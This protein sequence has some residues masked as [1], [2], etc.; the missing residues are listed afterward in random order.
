MMYASHVNTYE[1]SDFPKLYI[2]YQL[3]M[4]NIFLRVEV[5]QSLYF[6]TFLIYLFFTVLIVD[7]YRIRVRVE[8]EFKVEYAFLAP[9]SPRPS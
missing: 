3:I 5:A 4:R 8:F 7:E 9:R 2:S 1:L 6:Y